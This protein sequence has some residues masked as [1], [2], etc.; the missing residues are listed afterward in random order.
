MGAALEEALAAVLN[1][2]HARSAVHHF[3]ALYYLN[4][5]SQF[6]FPS[7]GTGSHG[8]GGFSSLTP[9]KSKD[10]VNSLPDGRSTITLLGAALALVGAAY[11]KIVRPTGL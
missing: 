11:Q 8:F 6:T 9:Y 5:A 4:E 2:L 7:Q 10:P 3:E 1:R